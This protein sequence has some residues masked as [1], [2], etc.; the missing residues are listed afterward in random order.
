MF[1]RGGK[2][3]FTDVHNSSHENLC[4][5]S[6]PLV[7]EEHIDLIKNVIDIL[8]N[9]PLCSRLVGKKIDIEKEKGKNIRDFFTIGQHLG[10][11]CG[12]YTD[13]RMWY[14]NNRS[15]ER[16]AYAENSIRNALNH[17]YIEVLHHGI[18]GKHYVSV[19]R[20]RTPNSFY[21]ITP[22]NYNYQAIRMMRLH[23]LKVANKTIRH[24]YPLLGKSVP[25]CA[26]CLKG[27]IQNT[28]KIA[29]LEDLYEL[30]LVVKWSL[31][32]T[33]KWSATGTFDPHTK[34]FI[35]ETK[36]GSSVETYLASF[37]R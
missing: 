26:L 25:L 27:I 10:E 19:L 15:R 8:E 21:V 18:L 5:L 20:K 1:F 16:L 2:R 28:P 12:A 23:A 7:P 37:N 36:C 31:G 13:T 17:G 9:E 3:K 6:L 24:I 14:E 32:F 35:L 4:C 33:R 34:K 30:D 22:I 29:T 11:L